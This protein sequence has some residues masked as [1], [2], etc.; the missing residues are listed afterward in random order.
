LLMLDLLLQ[1]MAIPTNLKD[2]QEMKMALECGNKMKINACVQMLH[3]VLCILHAENRMGLKIFGTAVNHGMKH[4]LKGDLYG[5]KSA[6]NKRFD[7]FFDNI[8]HVM[9][10][11]VLGNADHLGQWE[12]P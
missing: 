4:A 7:L 9:N 6:T 12:C 8:T 11:E 3:A 2:H 1:N 5:N 10:T